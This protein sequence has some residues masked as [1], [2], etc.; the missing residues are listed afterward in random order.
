MYI[1]TNLLFNEVI[2]HG[3]SKMLLLSPTISL[4]G[5]L[6][7]LSSEEEGFEVQKV[8]VTRLLS[9]NTSITDLQS[10]GSPAP[11]LKR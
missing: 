7:L 2:R 10:P 9:C 1:S 4:A 6:V 8:K 5:Q 11:N 3:F